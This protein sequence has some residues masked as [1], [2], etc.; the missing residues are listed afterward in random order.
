MK[1]LW[2]ALLTVLFLIF[3]WAMYDMLVDA[4]QRME[5]C[6]QKGGAMLRGYSS[7]TKHA[8]CVKVIPL[9]DWR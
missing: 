5:E 3:V 7:Y 1:K 6:R 2:L 8:V 4:P 9:E